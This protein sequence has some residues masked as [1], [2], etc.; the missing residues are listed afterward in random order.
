MLTSSCCIVKKSESGIIRLIRTA[1]KA[2]SK[3]GSE[4]SGVFHSFTQYLLSNG[5]K[6]NP[7]ATFR[8]NRFNIVF[9]DA[10]ALYY[11][12]SLVK[13][14]FI[15]VWQTPNQLLRAVLADIQVPEYLAGCRALGLVN[16]CVT[17]PLWR[18]LETPRIS[19]LQMNK[20]FLT[21][22]TRLEQWGLM[23]LV[24]CVVNKFFF[25]NSLQLKTFVFGRH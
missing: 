25:L 24:Y 10:G 17:G 13:K 21:L 15:E 5:I 22:V 4:Q 11:I 2:L 23:P 16:K 6:R 12:S 8:G 18:I 1:C 7:L 19:I 9:Y 14:F 20:Y 3:H